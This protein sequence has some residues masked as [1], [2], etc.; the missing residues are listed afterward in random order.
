MKKLF[1]PKSIAI[2]GASTTPG[3]LGYSILSNIVHSD[4]KG[5]IYPVNPHADEIL[6]K[7]VYPSVLK[8][9]KKVDLAVIAIPARF[10]IHAVLECIN[11][12]IFNIVII[13]AGFKEIGGEGIKLEKE[14]QKII[15]EHDVNL[16]G[17]NCLGNSQHAY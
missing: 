4:Y 2:V 9:P 15:R 7:K 14:L 5:E 3:K 12:D 13:S 6:G 17:P 16:V 10:V 8:L 11:K 1:H